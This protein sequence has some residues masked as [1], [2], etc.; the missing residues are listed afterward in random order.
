MNL[1]SKFFTVI[2]QTLNIALCKRDEIM[3]RRSDYKMPPADLNFGPPPGG[4]KSEGVHMCGFHQ[5]NKEIG[6]GGLE[7]GIIKYQ[8]ERLFYFLYWP[9]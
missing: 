8:M 1:Q 7:G 4:I 9:I 2:T 6:G 3:D 5:E